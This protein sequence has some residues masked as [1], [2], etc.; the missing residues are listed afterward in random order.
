MILTFS[1]AL[2]QT[3]TAK[4]APL[5]SHVSDRESIAHTI[6]FK[7]TFDSP[8]SYV[9]AQSD[10]FRVELWTNIPIHGHKRPNGE[11]RAVQF[12]EL[13][14]S[15]EP[16][17]SA[18]PFSLLT[19]A[20]EAREE[21]T[22]YLKLRASLHDH[23]GARFSYTFRLVHA[24]GH[25][26]WLG[27]HNNNGT[28]VVEQGIPGISLSK[29]WAVRDD[30]KY[31]LEATSAE[32]STVRLDRPEDWSIWVWKP[33]SL[34][35]Q[36]SAPEPCNGSAMVLLPR[37]SPRLG[38]ALKPLVLVASESASLRLTAD[39]DIS[40]DSIGK[41]KRAVLGILEHSKDLLE[42]AAALSNGTVL[43]FD[44]ASA[45]VAVRQ[46]NAALPYH[47]IVLPV[48][49]AVGK[50]SSIAV[51]KLQ[52]LVE[53]SSGSHG[54]VLFSQKLRKAKVIDDSLSN[55]SNVLDFGP[56]G[57]D[58]ILSPARII[59]ENDRTWQVML[60]SPSKHFTAQIEKPAAPEVPPTPPP[61]PPA[62][63]SP[64]VPA[65]TQAPISEETTVPTPPT[66]VARPVP[67]SPASGGNDGGARYVSRRRR[68]SLAL[69]RNLPARLVRAYL[70]AIFNLV[71]WFWSVFFKAFAVR[72]VGERV[73]QT[74]TRLLGYALSKT[75][76][77]P[78][79]TAGGAAPR[80]RI[81]STPSQT[82]LEG[83][84]RASQRDSSTIG[85]LIKRG[86]TE[87]VSCGIK[88]GVGVPS[89]ADTKFIPAP[90][91]QRPSSALHGHPE[92]RVVVSASLLRDSLSP[93]VIVRGQGP[94]RGLRAAFDGKTVPAPTV[95][96]L[97]DDFHL[98]ELTGLD[99]EEG[100][101][102]VSFEL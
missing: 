92:A 82:P 18:Q 8:Q 37:L 55:D 27:R 88:D 90:L 34:P 31:G 49:E 91:P 94:I 95:T 65:P 89:G 84:V 83:S 52:P 69:I 70:H 67:T 5:P 35:T 81:E 87:G 61:S 2:G 97:G 3:T 15:K 59:S 80:N 11:W 1:P 9:R 56:S 13:E 46:S 66:G 98:V 45:V 50:P 23:I 71:F 24:S 22:L 96:P 101:L 47:V 76:T 102:E 17:A 36:F 6:L 72:I 44:P 57:V 62:V 93:S 58:M 20:D 28:I 41:D 33:S 19:E 53:Q 48:A 30:G 25:V 38:D 60:L 68:S 79:L 40:V 10:K 21:N 86:G 78:S 29:H 85:G 99:G 42:K 32:G 74:I 73:P 12:T 43:A 14:G 75:A 54:L 16:V 77:R 100:Q 51:R 64:F 7:A 39:G 63:D 4:V 26:E